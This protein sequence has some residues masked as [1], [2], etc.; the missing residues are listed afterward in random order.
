VPTGSRSPLPGET[1]LDLWVAGHTILDHLLKVAELPEHDRTVPVVSRDLRL[2]GTAANIARAAAGWGVRVGLLS[3]V[4]GDFPPEFRATLEAEKVDLRGFEQVTGGAS[5]ACFIAEDGHGG[6]F[7]LIDQGP[8]RTEGGWRPPLELLADAPWLHLATGPP[9]DLLALK[10]AARARG[11]RVAVDPAQEIHYRWAAPELRRLLSG[12]EIL[13]GNG[14]EIKR[15][16]TLLGCKSPSELLEFVPLV[17]VTR[18]AEGVESY[19]REGVVR[20]PSEQPKRVTQVTG[21]GDAFRGGFY[22][23]WF[24]GEPLEACL[25]AGVRSAGRWIEAGGPNRTRPR[26]RSTA[27]RRSR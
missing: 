23:G 11:L 5:S 9:A 13:F 20:V 14:A 25:R 7:T 16:L 15:V 27:A 18:G 1:P 19:S 8:F 26:K 2:G 6:Q 12:S 21:A 22:A 10:D 4:G 3:E 17:V 24:A